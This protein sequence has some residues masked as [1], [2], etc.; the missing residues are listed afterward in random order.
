MFAGKKDTTVFPGV[1]LKGEEFFKHYGADVLSEFGLDAVHTH[2]TDNP[3]LGACTT[4]GSP[5]ISYCKY[6]GAL[7]ALNH[8][9]R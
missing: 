7:H 6:N 3:S 8:I 4:A 2:P 5:Y 1:G 9:S